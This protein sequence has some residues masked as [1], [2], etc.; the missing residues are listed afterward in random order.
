MLG[1]PEGAEHREAEQV[2]REL[3]PQVLQLVPQRRVV[4]RVGLGQP[5]GSSTSSVIATAN[6]PSASVRSRSTL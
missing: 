2:R 5:D 6:T 3:R 4:V 1:Q